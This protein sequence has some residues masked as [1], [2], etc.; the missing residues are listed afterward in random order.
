MSARAVPQPGFG[1]RLA[2]FAAYALIQGF[3]ALLITAARGQERIGEKLRRSSER[4][5]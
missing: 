2:R 3:A 4:L 5:R 1:K